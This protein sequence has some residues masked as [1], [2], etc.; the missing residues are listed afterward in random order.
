MPQGGDDLTL[1]GGLHLPIFKAFGSK[2][3]TFEVMPSYHG[4]MSH[5]QRRRITK[6]GA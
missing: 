2:P 6:G 3:E 4:V 5:P 1:H